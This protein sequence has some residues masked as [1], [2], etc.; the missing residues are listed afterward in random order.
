VR[1][2]FAESSLR[3]SDGQQIVDDQPEGV[4][5]EGEATFV[6]EKVG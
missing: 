4:H 6:R 2:A 3:R 1:P 5:G